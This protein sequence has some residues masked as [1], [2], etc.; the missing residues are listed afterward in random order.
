MDILE[1]RDRQ[2]RGKTRNVNQKQ[3]DQHTQ[4]SLQEELLAEGKTLGIFFDNFSV[5]I[6]KTNQTESG[7]DEKC[8]PDINV[9]QICPEQGRDYNRR[10]NQQP[11]HRWRS[12]LLQVRF[13]AVGSDYLF[14]LKCLQ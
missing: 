6:N 9:R 8:Q 12:L 4:K 3:P 10:Q 7:N 5:V 2:L 14:S 1:K 11:S 13:R